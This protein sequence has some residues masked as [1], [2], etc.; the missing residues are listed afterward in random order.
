M[1][2]KGNINFNLEFMENKKGE[3]I[4]D[5]KGSGHIV[6]IPLPEDIDLGHAILMRNLDADQDTRNPFNKA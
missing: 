5:A 6:K 3:A 2:P 4:S 1:T